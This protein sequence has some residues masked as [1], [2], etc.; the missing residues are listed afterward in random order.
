VNVADELFHSR[1]L[2]EIGR[3]QIARWYVD[4]AN[5][6]YRHVSH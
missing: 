2:V 4:T 5:S 1:S 6:I 3:Q